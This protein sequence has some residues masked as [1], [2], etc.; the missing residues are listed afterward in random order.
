MVTVPEAIDSLL[1]KQ[2]WL[3]TSVRAIIIDEIHLMDGDYRGDHLRV[4]MRRIEML[5]KRELQV[6]GASA[7]VSEPTELWSR[8]GHA[9]RSHVINVAGRRAISVHFVGNRDRVRDIIK[10]SHFKKGIIFCNSRGGTEDTTTDYKRLLGRENVRTHHGK[11]HKE[12]REPTEQ[13][14]IDTSY[15]FVVATMTLEIGIDI[16]DIDVAVIDIC[17]WSV[18]S[19]AQR[20]GRACRNED[21]IEV[22]MRYTSHED[23]LAEK[24]MLRALAE[25]CFEQSPYCFDLSVIIQQILS[26]CKTRNIIGTS[27][28]HL[29][30]LLSPFCNG[31]DLDDILAQMLSLQMI[32]QKDSNF[33]LAIVDRSNVHSNV[34][35]SPEITV[36]NDATKVKV[37]FIVP[38]VEETFMLAGECWRM[39]RFKDDTLYVARANIDAF[40]PK[41]GKTATKGHYFDMLPDSIKKRYPEMEA[42]L[43]W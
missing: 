17:P 1:F 21:K 20:I 14:M 31:R 35:D 22:I 18:S 10:E 23:L 27:R 32:E 41:F 25:S 2:T 19:L 28:D 7:T 30:E 24:K 8:Y 15:G 13:W 4:L 12:S 3:F 26:Y 29:F 38:P 6:I 9:G 43:P 33:Y 42:N 40:A 36:V 39:L 37:G 34:P 11:V 5:S 16:G